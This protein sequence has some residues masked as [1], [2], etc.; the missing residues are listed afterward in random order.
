MSNL[1]SNIELYPSEGNKLINHPLLESFILKKWQRVK[2]WFNIQF[3]ITFFFVFAF[4]CF[5]SIKCLRK[6]ESFSLTIF[7]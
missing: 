7:Y 1:L 5:S 2:I 3:L 6:G 4:S